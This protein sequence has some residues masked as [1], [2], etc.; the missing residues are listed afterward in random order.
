MWCSITSIKALL[1]PSWENNPFQPLLILKLSM[2]E[3]EAWKNMQRGLWTTGSLKPVLAWF[4]DPYRCH[5]CITCHNKKVYGFNDPIT[6]LPLAVL[7][8]LPCAYRICKQSFEK[9][10]LLF[11]KAK[12][13]SH[14]KRTLFLHNY[15]LST[16]IDLRATAP[17]N[18]IRATK[19]Q[20]QLHNHN[21]MNKRSLG[22]E[23]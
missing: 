2:F 16:K 3:L 14:R 15:N 10:Y 4:K 18:H 17:L 7:T 22:G 1:N 8:F 9:S 13:Y 20:S 6:S 12:K 23:K 19:T 21:H 11:T 5:F